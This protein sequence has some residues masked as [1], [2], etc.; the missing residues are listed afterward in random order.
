MAEVR[1]EES[2]MA[3]ELRELK[4][5]RDDGVIDESLFMEKSRQV[6]GLPALPAKRKAP[7]AATPPPKKKATPP[8]A[9]GAPTPPPAQPASIDLTN[10]T[11]APPPPVA[12]A[13]APVAP[14][15]APPAGRAAAAPPAPGRSCSRPGDLGDAAAMARYPA[16]DRRV[17]EARDMGTAVD[18]DTARTTTRS[19]RRRS[20][21]RSPIGRTPSTR[22]C[23]LDTASR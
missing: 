15:V 21:A 7:P 8:A 9:P 4:K 11:E 12:A 10:D 6:L 22:S 19:R 16:H 18:A 23:S 20:A 2:E 1:A 13:A 3:K 5:L 14:P 17:L